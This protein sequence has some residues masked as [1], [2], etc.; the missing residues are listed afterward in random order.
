MR[1]D[2]GATITGAFW[3]SAGYNS[4][5]K[6]EKGPTYGIN[7]NAQ[8]ASGIYGNSTT[9]TPNSLKIAFYISY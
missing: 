8:L 9:V 5:C 7:L 1:T 3:A 6:G 2:V 4:R